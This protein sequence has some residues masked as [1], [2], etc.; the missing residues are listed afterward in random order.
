VLLARGHLGEAS[1]RLRVH[2]GALDRRFLQGVDLRLAPLLLE[3][4]PLA[5]LFL[6]SRARRSASTFSCSSRSCASR[7]ISWMET[8]TEVS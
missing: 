5:L 1:L 6:S 7:R 8:I 2:A 3:G 4:A